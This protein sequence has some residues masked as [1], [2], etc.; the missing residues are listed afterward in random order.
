[1]GKILWRVFEVVTVY[2]SVIEQPDPRHLNQMLNTETSAVY[3]QIRDYLKRQDSLT[4]GSKSKR[5][6]LGI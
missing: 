5:T 2:S 1:M 6:A 3:S 4:L